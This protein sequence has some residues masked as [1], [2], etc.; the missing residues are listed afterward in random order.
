M[1]KKYYNAEIG[2][3]SL[4]IAESRSVASVILRGANEADWLRFINVDNPLQKRTPASAQ[5]QTRLLR[6]RLENVP[7]DLLLIVVEGSHEATVQ[8]LLAASIKH[9]RLLGDFLTSVVREHLRHFEY[10]LSDADWDRF[11]SDCALGEPEVGMWADST[12]KK[13]GQVVFRILAEAKYLENTRTR[14]ITPVR[15]L[16][17]VRHCLESHGERYAL[18]CMTLST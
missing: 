15:V 17:D 8:A 1:T 5:R 9:S 14:R 18:D 4:L 13:L 11:L 10:C 3:G 6:N 2:A 7:H 12:K 16:P